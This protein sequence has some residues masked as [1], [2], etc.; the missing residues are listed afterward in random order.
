MIFDLR[1]LNVSA[2]RIPLKWEYP[3]NDFVYFTVVGGNNSYR[4][5]QREFEITDL[6]PD[7]EYEIKIS[8]RRRDD[9]FTEPVIIKVRTTDE[10]LPPPIDSLDVSDSGSYYITLV[11]DAVHSLTGV[12]EYEIYCDGDLVGSTTRTRYTVEDLESDCRYDFGVRVIDDNRNPSEMY[13]ECFSTDEYYDEDDNDS[14]YCCNSI[15]SYSHKPTPEFY[16][17]GNWLSG[18]ELEVDKGSDKCCTASGV[19][20]RLPYVY[21][22]EDG[23]LSNGFEIVS[24]PA[25]LDYHKSQ[26]WQDTF[27]YLVDCGF[28]SHN[29]TT[30]GL[31]V[32]VNRDF[33][34]DTSD[35]QDLGI[36]KVLYF[37]EKFWDNVVIISR[38][39]REQLEQWANRYGLRNGETPDELIQKAKRDGAR[40]RAI[41]LGNR[42]TIEFRIFRGTLKY[43]TF[44]ATLEFVH[45][46][47][48][49]CADT[50]PQDLMLGSWDDFTN[51]VEM[52]NYD[53]L[54][55]YLREKGL[56]Q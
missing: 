34:G 56:M 29:T 40:Y 37:V 30:C 48:H 32:H 17:V 25:S 53:S 33:F 35:A 11:W 46:V 43:S 16:G 55:T 28:R 41:N 3:S 23:S 13:T 47:T 20:S 54:V 6:T 39:K 2:T 27:Q 22:K 38:R 8:A 4:S 51:Y 1:A 9:T 19:K 42:N 36:M 7:T 50:T 52:N 49:Y 45:A 18:V 31:H 5:Y 14:G 24:H 12:R 10:E 44:I 21:C 15:N 26:N